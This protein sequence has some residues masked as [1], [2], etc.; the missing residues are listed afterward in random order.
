MQPNK[1]RPQYCSRSY[2]MTYNYD[3]AAY[4]GDFNSAI[5]ENATP[6]EFYVNNC[7]VFTSTERYQEEANRTL[8]IDC[9]IYVDC[10]KP[11][12]ALA[13]FNCHFFTEDS[14]KKEDRHL[15]V[16]YCTS[17]SNTNSFNSQCYIHVGTWLDK[18]AIAKLATEK[19][20][21]R[22]GKK[23]INYRQTNYIFSQS[24]VV[25]G[26]ELEIPMNLERNQQHL[27]DKRLWKS[28]YDSSQ[29]YG[30]LEVVSRPLVYKN[31]L[32]ME[33][34]VARLYGKL[35]APT[36]PDYYQ[37]QN[38]EQDLANNASGSGI[39][40]H[41]SWNDGFTSQQL[42]SMLY[43]I[44]HQRGGVS[45]LL[46]EGG[47]SH[48]SF[49]EYSAYKPLDRDVDKYDA[50]NCYSTRRLEMRWMANS[51]SPSVVAHRIRTAA[52]LYA[53][54]VVYLQTKDLIESLD[55]RMKIG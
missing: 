48:R 1:K 26:I 4:L 52:L 50:F 28:T 18:E 47:K 25:C 12:P 22:T 17:S 6:P 2:A 55:K 29:I 37:S 7:M 19:K 54:A 34:R 14:I 27:I 33:K 45:W 21:A 43:A 51:P 44:V 24:S 10:A 5:Q 32:D 8:F 23:A 38:K 42:R 40:V 11:K 31:L 46:Q 16:L 30:S 49:K 36:Q 3:N 35:G 41:F 13:F 15:D 20:L 9:T 39:H 53:E